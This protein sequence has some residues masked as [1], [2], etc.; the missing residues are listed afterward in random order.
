MRL[1]TLLLAGLILQ[2][3]SADEGPAISVSGVRVLAPLPGSSI[4]VA[5]L[6]ID[7]NSGRPITINDVRSPQFASVEMHETTQEDGVSAMRMLQQIVVEDGGTVQLREGGL[8]LMLKDAMPGAGPG[9]PVSLEISHD[10]GLLIVSAVM[11]AR[12]PA[13]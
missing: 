12:L 10:Q 2:A 8:H 9:A 6:T 4:G 5:Y 11:Q 1:S 3:C 7:N 13:E